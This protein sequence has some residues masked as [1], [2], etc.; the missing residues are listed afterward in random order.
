MAASFEDVK[1]FF[2]LRKDMLNE[3]EHKTILSILS[4]LSTLKPDSERSEEY[5]LLGNSAFAKGDLVASLEHYNMAIEADQ[6]N[7]LVYSNRALI[8][9]KLKNNE[10]AIKDCL[11]G[12]EIQPTFVKFYIRLAMIYSEKDKSKAI[13]YCEKGLSYEPDNTI[14]KD[15]KTT[16]SINKPEADDMDSMMSGFDPSKIGEMMKDEKMMSMVNNLIKDKSPDELSK[17]MNDMLSKLKK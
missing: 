11:K 5:K 16:L 6:T 15:L 7:Y 12:I 8:Q 4:K 10:E 14:L 9:H 3:N 2:E 13:E 1:Q 17:M